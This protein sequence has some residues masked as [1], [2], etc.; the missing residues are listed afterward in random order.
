[1]VEPIHVGRPTL[2]A[3]GIDPRLRGGVGTNQRTALAGGDLLVRVEAE[4]R[5][6]AARADPNAVLVDSA[7]RLAGVLDDP[8]AVRPGEILE[9][10][11]VGGVAEDV[12]RQKAGR[13]RADGG[14]CGVRIDVERHRID[15]AENRLGALVEDA[16]RRGDEAERCRH[17]LVA[18]RDPRC[19][20]REM[21]RSRSARHRRDVLDAEL[22]RQRALE[23]TE[24]RPERQ[25]PGAQRCEHHRQLALADVGPRE[26]DRVAGMR[27]CARL[28]HSAGQ[29]TGARR[30]PLGRVCARAGSAAC[31]PRA[32]RREL[33]SS[34]R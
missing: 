33:P 9:T 13:A 34:P 7:E 24:H 23:L 26:R 15:V 3:L 1:M 4:R 21:E 16:V 27:S 31:P 18:G 10:P 30:P 14:A 5:E 6:V 20:H 2:V 32:S 28:L 8:Q 11:H 12:H 17:Y 25:A 22:L 19:P 29:P